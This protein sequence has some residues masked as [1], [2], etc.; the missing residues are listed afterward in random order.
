MYI[1]IKEFNHIAVVELNRSPANG[2]SRGFLMEFIRAI[3]KVDED[4][5]I[6]IVIISSKQSQIFSSGL[7][8]RSLMGDNADEMSRNIFDAVH[9]VYKIVE[10]I[11]LSKKIFIGALSG[12]TIGSAVSVA[13]ACD[14]LIGSPET[15]FWLPDPQ[16]GG[17][18]ADGGIDLLINH[19]GTS[20]AKMLALTNDRINPQRALE[21]GILYRVVE[22]GKLLDVAFSEA[23]RLSGY[24][25]DTLSYTKRLINEGIL[26]SFKCDELKE[27]LNN[28]EIYNRLQNYIKL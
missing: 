15:W 10:K 8:L 23:K 25:T 1:K 7:D 19:I 24:S 6:K 17:L 12:A 20:R 2:F 3:K 22:K 27:I 4:R 18:L 9:L 16:Y 26:N 13:L 5:S 11:M 14:L 21:W 28:R